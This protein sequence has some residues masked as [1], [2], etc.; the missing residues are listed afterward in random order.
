MKSGCLIARFA[1]LAAAGCAMPPVERMLLEDRIETGTRIDGSCGPLSALI[2]AMGSAEK[3]VLIT[4]AYFADGGHRRG[5][6]HRGKGNRGA[7][8]G[9]RALASWLAGRPRR[10]PV[11]R[12]LQ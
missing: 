7:P 1:L 5:L 3:S 4:M 11:M 9:V 10:T 12:G 6:V 2:S 8:V